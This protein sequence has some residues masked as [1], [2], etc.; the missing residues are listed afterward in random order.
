MGPSIARTCVPI[1]SLLTHRVYLVPAHTSARPTGYYD[2]YR[3]EVRSYSFVE[4]QNCCITE[5]E[6]GTIYDAEEIVSNETRRL[7]YALWKKLDSHGNV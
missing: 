7:R 3:I 5:D 1:S 4:G 6:L 2:S